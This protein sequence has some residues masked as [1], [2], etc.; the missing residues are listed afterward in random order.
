MLSLLVVLA[1]LADV[2]P[3]VV[4]AGSGYSE[5]AVENGGTIFGRVFFEKDF[6]KPERIQVT[7]DNDVCGLRKTSE[8]FVVDPESKGLA[9]V[10]VRI[11]GITSGKSFSTAN[12]EIA[13]LNCRYEPHVLVAPRGEKLKIVNK[14]ALLHNIHAYDDTTTLF[15]L[16][17][18]IKDQV[19]PKK[20]PPDTDV[21]HLKCD[22][23]S[24]MEAYVIIIDNPYVAITGA[25]GRFSI[26]DV[27]PGDYTLTMW[28]EMLGSSSK[29]V[30]VKAGGKAQ[31]DF[32]I[33]E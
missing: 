16:A 9:N 23:H 2:T 7:R 10:V 18:P 22:V 32:S 20:L 17:Q 30:S 15:N 8:Q 19:T 4:Q 33:G 21:V 6:P 13:Q 28:H 3:A 29:E 25:D 31:V 11:E 1:L 14:D 26:G 12:P 5:V 24:W 27:P